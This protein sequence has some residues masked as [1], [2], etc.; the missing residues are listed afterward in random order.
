MKLPAHLLPGDCIYLLAPAKA[1][2]LEHVAFAKDFFEQNGYHVRIGKHC[3]GQHHYFSGT[4]EERAAD[5]QEALDDL[6]VKAIICCRGGYG[7]VRIVDRVQWA[8]FLRDPKWIVGFSDVTVFHQ[9]IQRYGL[10]SIHAT[11]PLNFKTNTTEALET[12]LAALRGELYELSALSCKHNMMGEAKGELIGGNLSIV[13]SLLG[14]DDQPEYHGKILFLEDL[15]EHLYHIDR[16]FFALAKAGILKKLAGVVIGGMTD[17]EDTAIPFGASVEELIR[18]HFKF[19]NIPLAFNF[20]A[21]HINDNRALIFGQEVNLVVDQNGSTL[22][23][24]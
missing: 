2:E 1:I 23:W 4:D 17:L 18:E 21:G 15:A 22:R 3:T 9:R 7:A 8:G 13:Y 12:L 20:P 6:H 19:I 5:L 10:P 11:M 24:I 14:S 16:M